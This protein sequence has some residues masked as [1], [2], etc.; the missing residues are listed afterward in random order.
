MND[1]RFFTKPFLKMPQIVHNSSCQH[2]N[3]IS[4]FTRSLCRSVIMKFSMMKIALALAASVTIHVSA[5]DVAMVVITLYKLNDSVLSNSTAELQAIDA[6]MNS[7]KYVLDEVVTEVVDE[8]APARHLRSGVE[9]KM[10]QHC[11]PCYGFHED[12][13]GCYVN[14][15]WKR[16]C[17]RALTIHQDISDAAIA[18]LSEEDRR[19]HL[20]VVGLCKEAKTGVTVAIGEAQ[21]KGIL[22]VPESGTLIEKCLYEYV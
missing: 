14:G 2:K 22:P 6:G 11:D 8:H 16:Q 9:R 18:E 21:D 5:Q 3:H 15:V 10:P 13:P 1:P 17:D 19:R 20:Y 12:Y 4:V 7:I